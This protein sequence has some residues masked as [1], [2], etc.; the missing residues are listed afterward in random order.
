M[1][2]EFGVNHESLLM[3]IEYFDIYSGVL[4]RDVMHDLFEGVLQYES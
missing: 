2:H 4:I 1:T 3:E